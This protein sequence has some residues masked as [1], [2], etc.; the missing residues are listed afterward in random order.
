MGSGLQ[1]LAVVLVLVGAAVRALAGQAAPPL[2][3][4]FE[5]AGRDEKIARAALD[6]LARTWRTGYTAMIV[7]MARLMRPPGAPGASA[8]P[9]E[10]RGV[11]DDVG[12]E[13]AGRRGDALD[14]AS[15]RPTHPSTIVRTRLVRFLE[16]QTGQRFG[17]D[18]GRWREWMWRLPYEPHPDYGAF[19]GTVYAQIDPGFTRFFPPGVRSLVRLDEVDWGGVKVNGIPPLK[20]PPHVPAAAATYLKD[21]HLVFGLSVGGQVRAYPKRI[22]AWHEMALDRLGGID[23]TVVYCT[24][25]GTLMPYESTVGARR[26]TFGT[27]GLLYQSNK[28]MFDEESSSLWSTLEGRPVIGTLAGSDLQLRVLPVVTTTWGE[29]RAEHPDTTVLSLDTGFERDYSEGA[30]YRDYFSTDRLMFRVSRTDARL[31][32]K[33]EVLVMLVGTGRAPV[34]IAVD[35]LERNPVY[36]LDAG[37]RS[38]VVVTS[39][40]GANRVYDTGGHRFGRR[41]PAGR[42]ADAAGVFWKITE[43]ALVLER[44][45]TRR[46]PRVAAQRAFW[47]GWFAQ[48]PSTILIK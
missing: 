23:L 41:V 2:S 14:A 40:E 19:K 37:G 16:K 3:L 45:P 5:A 47:F 32:N 22:L 29:W 18:L 20:N 42:I 33:A 43:D 9:D 48:F 36:Q 12:Q 44:D 31:K 13:T 21:G 26:F 38:L 4:F 10:F 1:R 7:D 8:S 39:P 6:Q 11:D 35:F 30:A 27:S 17:H 28:L 25:C 46:L 34:A 24:L 15:P